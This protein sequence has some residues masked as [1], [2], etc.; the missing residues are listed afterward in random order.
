MIQF[1][2]N[3]TLITEQALDPGTTVLNYL[4]QN[5]RR[6]GTKEGC[7]SGDCGA[8]TVTLGSVEA[9]KMVY[10]TVNSCIT[11]VSSLQGK[12]LLTVED[13]RQG[14]ELHEVQKALAGCHASQC[15]FCTPGFVM[16]LFTLQKNSDGW[17]RKAAEQALAGNL[18][19]CTGYRPI[20]DAARQVCEQP[21][22]DVFAQREAQTVE[23][24]LAIQNREEQELALNGNRCLLPKS[25]DR[26]A[27][28]LLTFPEAKLLA[29]GTDLALQVTQNH[30]ALPLVIA[31]DG[32]ETL[33]ACR[34][35]EQTIVLGAGASLQ[36][37]A[38]LLQPH[39][40][41]FSQVLERFASLQI[42]NRGT[43]GGNIANGS[44]IGDTPPMLLALNATLTLQR[45]EQTR[46]LPLDAF[47]L[48]YRQTALQPGEFIRSITLPK[49]TASQHFRAWKVSKRLEDDISA[50]FGAFMLDRA[51]DGTV[52]RAR[53]AFGGMAATPKRATH[54]EHALT[55][56]PLTQSSLA[57]ACLAL[58]QDFTPLS[59]FRASASY[60]LQV[61]KNLLRR[62]HASF[63][64]EL[65]LLE[66]TDYVQ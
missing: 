3:Q 24:L 63:T 43:L 30:K 27:E 8:C 6:C 14:N 65:T 57:L 52:T 9:G 26:L 46:T 22:P 49:L 1:L 13:L 28:L 64:E 56:K 25:L 33:K 53:I 61:A 58:E 54:C 4:R 10:E 42:R 62:Y 59:D 2:L 34:E 17:Q 31:L 60:R 20:I 23:K 50:V 12:Q 41:V 39:I 37:C 15:G 40:P 36:A 55:G 38:R 18:C 21:K 47:F 16:S 11:F 45:G 7:A 48:G 5:R 44:P 51:A 32:V 19:R 66:V 35:E 29:G